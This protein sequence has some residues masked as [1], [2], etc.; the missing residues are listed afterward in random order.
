MEED[1]DKE[2]DLNL[3]LAEDKEVDLNLD[4]ARTVIGMPGKHMVAKAPKGFDPL[5][6]RRRDFMKK[7][8]HKIW[9]KIVIGVVYIYIKITNLFHK[10]K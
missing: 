5:R 8:L 7:W 9:V 4:L 10:K 2:V 1:L 6:F 3:D